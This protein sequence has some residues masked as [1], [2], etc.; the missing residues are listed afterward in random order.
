MYDVWHRQGGKEGGRWRNSIRKMRDEWLTGRN[1]VPSLHPKL[2]GRVKVTRS[3]A[4]AL[5]DLFLTRWRYGEGD[6]ALSAMTRDG[7]VGFA[8]GDRQRCRNTLV[9]TMFGGLSDG[10]GRAILLPEQESRSS[11]RTDD[12]RVETFIE[13]D[14]S[15]CDALITFSRGRIAVGP[16][17]A[18]TIKSFVQFFRALYKNYTNE[19][20][21]EKI[22][23]WV[24]DFGQR[25]IELDDSFV[26]YFNA[27]FLSLLLQAFAKF[28]SEADDSEI[29]SKLYRKLRIISPEEQRK[30]WKWLYERSVIVVENLRLSE[31]SSMYS[32]E[33]DLLDS[34]PL[35][36]ISVTQQH[37]LP[38]EIPPKWT[39]DI[40]SL[41]GRNYNL[42][43]ISFTVLYNKD[44][45]R[46]LEGR[47]RNFKYYAHARIL[48][49]PD[50]NFA[51]AIVQSVE[52]N[53]PDEEYD[54]AY[55]ILYRAALGRL[56]DDLSGDPEGAT[57]LAYLRRINF[58]VLRI[59]DFL[60]V[61][62]LDAVESMEKPSN[63]DDTAVKPENSTS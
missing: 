42:Q 17:P 44:G 61:H 54:D 58:H 14:F 7:Y 13:S 25:K 29:H 23:V 30:R 59:P 52:L 32:K 51:T 46:G 60:R 21:K 8:A 9:Q 38:Q 57:A 37:V 4:R 28:D 34:L 50:A 53:P 27:G 55:E 26:E 11:V 12:L 16:S 20:S 41:T 36:G 49:S 6:D 2:M 19:K 33:Y 40:K 24:V 5:T 43:N 39:K 31:V 47:T 15:E 35:R 62:T 56:N 63:H 18:N 48:Q 45:W 1:A 10:S 3:D 22:F